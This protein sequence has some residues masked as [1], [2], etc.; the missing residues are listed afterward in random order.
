MAW[1]QL[2]TPRAL[3]GFALLSR[4]T[5]PNAGLTMLTATAG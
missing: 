3:L 5:P 1:A 2:R 4:V